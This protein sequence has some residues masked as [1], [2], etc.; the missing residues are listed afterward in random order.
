MLFLSVERH[1]LFVCFPKATRTKFEFWLISSLFNFIWSGQHSRFFQKPKRNPSKARPKKVACSTCFPQNRA[2]CNSR[3]SGS[4]FFFLS[5]RGQLKGEHHWC[6]SAVCEWSQRSVNV[7]SLTAHFTQVKAERPLLLLQHITCGHKIHSGTSL[8]LS[9]R[10]AH[11][12]THY[13]CV[14]TTT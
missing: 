10:P 11:S 7:V 12:N 4:Y 1:F 14:G 9:W 8:R 6:C 13:S 5:N 2:V 3:H